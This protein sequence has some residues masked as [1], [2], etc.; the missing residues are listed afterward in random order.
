MNWRIVCLLIFMLVFP[1]NQ[2]FS[3]ETSMSLPSDRSRVKIDT[4][5]IPDPSGDKEVNGYTVRT[6]QYTLLRGG[7]VSFDEA[8]YWDPG[9]YK[10]LHEMGLN[11]VRFVFFDA[12]FRFNEGTTNWIDF[13]DPA[14]KILFLQKLEYVVDLCS[15]NGLYLM[16]NYHDVFSYGRDGECSGDCVRPKVQYAIEFWEK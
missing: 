4:V 10:T 5:L 2:P 15:A 3:Q 1:F 9:Y 8:Y 6:N 14:Q 7:S 16:I 13:N 12:Y 11:A